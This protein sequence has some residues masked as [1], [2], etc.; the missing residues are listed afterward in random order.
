MMGYQSLCFQLP[1]SQAFHPLNIFA[2]YSVLFVT[3]GFGIH[4]YPYS[5][6]VSSHYEVTELLILLQVPNLV[7]TQLYLTRNQ[8]DLEVY[9]VSCVSTIE[10]NSILEGLIGGGD[11]TTGG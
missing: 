7:V 11:T 2:L 8:E 3:Y 6:E 4:S 5:L 1:N 10:G 9:V